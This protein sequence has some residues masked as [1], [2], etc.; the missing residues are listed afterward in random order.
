MIAKI[1]AQLKSDEG[2]EVIHWPFLFSRT[3]DRMRGFSLGKAF[4]LVVCLSRL[5]KI[6]F[7]GRID[8]LIFPAG[9]PQ[10]V[11]VVRDIL[12]LPFA[13]LTSRRLIIQFHAAGI[14]DKLQNSGFPYRLAA[15]LMR[16]ADAAVVMTDYNRVDP[17][18]VGIPKIHVLPHRI[19]DAAGEHLPRNR[20]DRG[21]RLLYVGHL[22]ADKGTQPLLQAFSAIRRDFPSASLELVGEPLPP[23]NWTQLRA[24]ISQLGIQEHVCLAGVLNGDEKWEA[25]RRAGLF[26]FP[27][28][29]PY[30]SFGL[31]LIEAMM[32]SL[33]VVVSDWRGNK[34]VVG[35]APGGVLFPIGGN[36]KRELE[37]AVRHAFSRSA[38]WEAWGMRNRQRYEA[39]FRSDAG[40]SDY[41]HLARNICADQTC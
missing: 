40:T 20:P 8:L 19:S 36:L 10:L 9:G 16:R 18:R 11:P 34:D 13:R 1:I 32:F 37:D 24:D 21:P 27:S 29:A 2:M 35:E 22:C 38:E 23:Y 15:M 28:V 12:L 6:R 5:F 26:V 39:L 17:R 31:V 41:A 3:V 14:A 4:E 25:F 7:A 30:E 33:P